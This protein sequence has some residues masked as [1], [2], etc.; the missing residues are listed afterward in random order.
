MPPRGRS[1]EVLVDCPACR[2]EGARVEVVAGEVAEES[3]CRLCGEQTREGR[4]TRPADSRDTPAKAEALL[5]RWAVEEAD[6]DVDAFVRA[7]FGAELPVVC[8]KLVAGERVET[9]LEV[10]AWLFG[11]RG[12]FAGVS[13]VGARLRAE[14]E[15]TDAVELAAPEAGP[16]AGPDPLDVTRA[17]AAA[18]MVDGR[19]PPEA[20]LAFEEARIALGAPELPAGQLRV[21]R[22]NE[23]GSVRDPAQTLAWMRRIALADGQVDPSELR[24]LRA[25]ARAWRVD[26]EAVSLD[27]RPWW[28]HLR[29][30]VRGILA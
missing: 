6:P 22:P 10:V 20:A 21:W 14:D 2:V 7:N 16:R 26:L 24:L 23:V 18:R 17:L 29:E 11:G 4:V 5:R 19:D 15:P 3:R 9:S 13:A 27:E 8:A 28:Q 12:A 1:V 25:Y 30:I